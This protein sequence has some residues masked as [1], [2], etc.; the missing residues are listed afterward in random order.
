MVWRS[1]RVESLRSTP[2]SSRTFRRNP[3]IDLREH[4]ITVTVTETV[5]S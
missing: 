4:R 3:P 5:N 1:A 2:A